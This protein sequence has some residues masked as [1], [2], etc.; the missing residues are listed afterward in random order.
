[1]PDPTPPD[2]A[3]PEP[4]LAEAV[5]LVRR[6]LLIAG[7]RYVAPAVLV[8]LSIEGRAWAQGSCRP[9]S[10][11]PVINNCG[12]LRVCRPGGNGG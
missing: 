8:S 7:G 9:H 5:D 10:C 1:M 12:P 11:P 6:R 4:E 2:E 3:D